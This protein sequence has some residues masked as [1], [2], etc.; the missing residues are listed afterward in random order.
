MAQVVSHQTVTL[1]AWLQSQ[2]MWYG[3]C[4]G[5]HDIGIDSSQ[6]TSAFPVSIISPLLHDHWVVCHLIYVI[7]VVYSIIKYHAFVLYP[8]Q[9]ANL[10]SD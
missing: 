1:E 5:W 6:S 4:A 10:P 2:A 9:D 3:I 7:P 8:N